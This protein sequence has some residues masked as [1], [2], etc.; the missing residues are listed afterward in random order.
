MSIRC[1]SIP[2]DM[3]TA[4]NAEKQERTNGGRQRVVSFELRRL[5]FVMRDQAVLMNLI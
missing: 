1:H 3:Y 2:R 5:D 4:R